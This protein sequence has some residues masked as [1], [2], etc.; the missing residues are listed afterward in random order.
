[1]TRQ[2]SGSVIDHALANF[3]VNSC[4]TVDSSLS[5]HYDVIV[6]LRFDHASEMSDEIVQRVI[7]YDR[8][9]RVICNELNANVLP[10]FASVD[11]TMS[12][13]TDVISTS[14]NSQP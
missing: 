4:Y 14:T 13:L 12:F 2:V 10:P 7:D 1:M 6:N 5:D 3:D 8:L 9:N 11:E